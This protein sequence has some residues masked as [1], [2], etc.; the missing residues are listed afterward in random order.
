MRCAPRSKGKSPMDWATSEV[1]A[2]ATPDSLLCTTSDPNA[3]ED[4]LLRIANG[5]RDEVAFP[6]LLAW[7]VAEPDLHRTAMHF[8]RLVQ[9]GRDTKS[10]LM[11]ALLGV[12][13]CGINGTAAAPEVV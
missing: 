6:R 7:G 12:V 4:R 10:G 3:R 8:V 5:I 11:A 9:C 13:R 1:A 2:S